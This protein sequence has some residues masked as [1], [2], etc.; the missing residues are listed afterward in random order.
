MHM[1]QR[2][3]CPFSL[4]ILGLLVLFDS[5][6]FSSLNQ[7]NLKYISPMI[8][9]DHVPYMLAFAARATAAA[10]AT[11]DESLSDTQ[12]MSKSSSDTPIQNRRV[13]NGLHG[14]QSQQLLEVVHPLCMDGLSQAVLNHLL[15]CLQEAAYALNTLE[16]SGLWGQEHF[17]GTVFPSFWAVSGAHASQ[18]SPENIQ[19]PMCSSAH[20]TRTPVRIPQGAPATESPRHQR[21]I[22]RLDGLCI[23]IFLPVL[24]MG[25][26]PI[27]FL[28]HEQDWLETFYRTRIEEFS[29]AAMSKEDQPVEAVCYAFDTNWF[30]NF[31]YPPIGM[32]PGQCQKE[33]KPVELMFAYPLI[34]ISGICESHMTEGWFPN[35]GEGVNGVCVLKLMGEA[36]LRSVINVGEAL[37]LLKPT[38]RRAVP[39]Q[40]LVLPPPPPFR[41]NRHKKF[42]HVPSSS[43][44][45]EE[46]LSKLA[47]QERVGADNVRDAGD[48]ARLA[49]VRHRDGL[50]AD[51]RGP[52]QTCGCAWRTPTFTA[53]FVERFRSAL[54]ERLLI[55]GASTEDIIMQY[56]STVKALNDMDPKWVPAGRQYLRTRPDTVRCIVASLIKDIGSEEGTGSGPFLSAEL[57]NFVDETFSMSHGEASLETRSRSRTGGPDALALLSIAWKPEKIEVRVDGDDPYSGGRKVKVRQI[58]IINML[59]DIYG[60]KE[61]FVEQYQC[62]PKSL[63]LWLPDL[64]TG[65]AMSAPTGARLLLVWPP[66]NNIA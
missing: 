20:S 21:Q 47:W 60:S 64:G 12:E 55:P 65:R 41:S 23:P 3:S 61:L 48:H 5:S 59:V 54:Q 36:W 31:P 44:P 66:A 62:A 51:P 2:G 15:R 7:Q 45:E 53:H 46:R 38:F 37:R 42:V 57:K 30:G 17:S 1:H 39:S 32:H 26:P 11:F 25:A 33:T 4:W 18:L 27:P 6:S 10:T 49:D 24:V 19:D 63:V 35:L 52:S 13:T 40:R 43:Q 50:P 9:V 16:C 56:V 34:R 14:E 28:Q 29:A 22:A 8:S 58:D